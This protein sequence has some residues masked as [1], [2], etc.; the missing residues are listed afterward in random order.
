VHGAS[1]LILWAC[2]IWLISDQ[3]R[4]N[5]KFYLLTI[6][7]FLKWEP[8]DRKNVENWSFG[9]KEWEFASYEISQTLSVFFKSQL[10]K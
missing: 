5:T 10:F 4:F 6:A 8:V 1:T 2:M 7:V 9:M 3:F